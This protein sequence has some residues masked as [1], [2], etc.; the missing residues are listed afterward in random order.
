MSFGAFSKGAHRITKPTGT[1]LTIDDAN[2][3]KPRLNVSWETDSYSYAHTEYGNPTIN[4]SVNGWDLGLTVQ[5]IVLQQA[6]DTQSAQNFQNDVYLNIN[7]TFKYDDIFDGIDCGK[8]CDSMSEYSEG[9]STTFGLQTG[10][11]FPLSASIQPGTI[12]SNTLHEFYFID[13][14]FEFIKNKASIHV[15]NY[16]VNQGLSTTTTYI[17]YML[18]SEIVIVPKNFKINCDFYSGRSN[19]SGTVIQG[20]FMLNENVEIFAGWAIATPDSGNYNYLLSGINLIKL[21]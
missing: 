10:T 13:N 14:D 5:N 1:S 20:T 9:M 8:F 16:Y 17:G 6:S 4:Y 15:G 11:V 3:D 2:E 21:F 12:N 7:K 18:G 19:V